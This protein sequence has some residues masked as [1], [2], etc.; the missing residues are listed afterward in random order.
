MRFANSYE[1]SVYGKYFISIRPG[2]LS[3][4]LFVT[5]KLAKMNKFFNQTSITI[6]CITACVTTPIVVHVLNTAFPPKSPTTLDVLNSYAI[7]ANVRTSLRNNGTRLNKLIDD[8]EQNEHRSKEKSSAK[9][10]DISKIVDKRQKVSKIYLEIARDLAASLPNMVAS[11][12]ETYPVA[13]E[14]VKSLEQAAAD[15]LV[16]NK[17]LLRYKLE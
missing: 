14:W 9:E 2:F 4:I 10:I 7:D 17:P 8:I 6:V 15:A 12:Y 13:K 5:I 11:D 3:K 16:L 1:F